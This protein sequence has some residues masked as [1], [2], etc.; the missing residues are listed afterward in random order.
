MASTAVFK[1]ASIGSNPIVLDRLSSINECVRLQILLCQ[2]KS[3]SS[4]FFSLLNIMLQKHIK[5]NKG[6]YILT[7]GSVAILPGCFIKKK[8]EFMRLKLDP[9]INRFWDPTSLHII[10]SLNKKI[11]QFTKK[12]N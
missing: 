1:I 8:N 4:L 5:K 11:I 9:M 7:D 2:F 10:D 12:Y 3:G 6:M